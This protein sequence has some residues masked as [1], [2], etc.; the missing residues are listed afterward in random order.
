MTKKKQASRP[1]A[2]HLR[3]LVHTAAS[4]KFWGFPVDETGLEDGFVSIRLQAIGE[5][6]DDSA[7]PGSIVHIRER[8]VL[9]DGMGT[10]GEP[11]WIAVHRDATVFEQSVAARSVNELRLSFLAPG[12]GLGLGTGLG[13]LGNI[14]VTLDPNGP[15]TPITQKPPTTIKI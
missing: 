12:L 8:D 10:D 6:P 13:T 5:E 3:D 11:G 14:P 2:N 4:E 9:A 7:E 1:Q 15:K